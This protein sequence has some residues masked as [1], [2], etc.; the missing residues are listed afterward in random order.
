MIA[1]RSFRSLAPLVMAAACSAALV[2]SGWSQVIDDGFFRNQAVGGVSIDAA[3]LLNEAAPADR[4]RLR[5]A[6]AENAAPLPQGMETAVAIRKIS[7]RRLDAALA[8]AGQDR[9]RDL[10]DAIAYLGGLQRIQ[11]V[12]VYPE[13]NDI[14]LAGPGEGWTLDPRGNVVGRT[15]GQ[16]VL[17]L[18][19]L[20]IAFRALHTAPSQGINCSIDPTEEGRLRLQAY[21]NR[22]RQFSPAV[23]RGAAEAMGVQKITVTGVP[24]DSRFAR[25]LVAAD[26]RMKRLAMKLE[27]T[28][29]AGL[30]SYLDLVSTS[31]AN[32][33]PRWWLASDYA[34]V[35]TSDDGLAFEF[36]ATRV[37]VMTEDEVVG[38]DGE[39][40][41]TG[42]E[43]AAATRF[44][45]AMTERYD[46]LSA[47]EP[48]FRELRNLMDLCLVAAVV[49]RHGLC[50]RA[51]LDLRTLF[52]SEKGAPIDRWNSPREVAT[53]CSFINRGRNYIITASG[54]V[55][56][57]PW[58]AVSRQ[59]IRPHLNSVHRK[60]AP[61]GEAW[62]WN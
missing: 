46:D 57:E 1:C 45:K 44:A 27:P 37:K 17:H 5:Q 42:R 29:V 4:V 10:P 58:Q 38:A 2:Q 28:P 39:I 13:E 49:E 43:S 24:A 32:A 61:L 26:Y 36:P 12:L 14:I 56:I 11:Y 47:A 34:P 51:G 31:G 50:S 40:N 3:G 55:Q 16:P 30:P 19:D 41:S 18:D 53:Q 8:D 62:W 48:V 6:L 59:E 60:V 22:Q 21:L 9:G 52:D 20:L 54:G 23:L 35:L 15:S 25:T 33:T 7:L